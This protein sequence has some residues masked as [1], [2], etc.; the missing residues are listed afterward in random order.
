[1]IRAYFIDE[2]FLKDQTAITKNVDPKELKP[3]LS[4]AQEKYCRDL[5]GDAQ[6]ERLED[7]IINNS[8]TNDENILLEKLSLPL[9]YYV[10]FEAYPSLK[11]KTRNIGVISTA[12]INQLKI[13]ENIFKEMRMETLSNAEYWAERVRVYLR[14][15][16][17]LYP[18]YAQCN[19][20]INADPH[21]NFVSPIYIDDS[22]LNRQYRDGYYLNKGFIK[23]YR[24]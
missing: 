3:F 4:L 7:A 9:A 18:L 23:N 12:D 13:D 22:C 19:K 6:Y 16:R 5:L 14:C 2:D 24:Y 17:D 20:D 21:S 1:M 15:N 8:K 10:L 11:E